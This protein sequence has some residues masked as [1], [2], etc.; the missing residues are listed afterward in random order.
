MRVKAK[1]EKTGWIYGTLTHL[2]LSDDNV[3]F[4]LLLD[5]A[6]FSDLEKKEPDILWITIEQPTL[7]DLNSE[8][9]QLGLSDLQPTR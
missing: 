4:S 7:S 1:H 3:V 2:Q 8:I 5:N 9:E 6:Q